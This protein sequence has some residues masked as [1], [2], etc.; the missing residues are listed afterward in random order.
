MR[1]LL[2]GALV[3]AFAC[4]DDDGDGDRTPASDMAVEG[5][6]Q[7]DRP[8]LPVIPDMN[9]SDPC[10]DG[11][12]DE[13]EACDTAIAD[14]EEGACPSTCADEDVCT[15]DGVSGT[16]CSATCTNAPITEPSTGDGCCPAGALPVNDRDCTGDCGNGTL[17]AGE[18]CDLGIPAGTPGACPAT[19]DDAIACTSD[20]MENAGTCMARCVYADIEAPAA[21]DGCCPDGANSTT[22]SDCSASCG[23][24]VVDPAETCDSGIAVG[25]PGA[26][27]RTCDDGDICTINRLRS[28]GTCNAACDF[29]PVP[30][31]SGDGCCAPGV[32]SRADSDCTTE[33]G[34]GALDL[35]ETCDDGNLVSGDGCDANCQS[36]TPVPTA[37]RITSLEVRDPHVFLP[38]CTID[39]TS[40]ANGIFMDAVERNAL[41]TAGVFR[42]IDP[43]APSTP[44]DVF[45]GAACTGA[46][47]PLDACAAS[48]PV[49]ATNANNQ[50]SGTCFAAP[51]STLSYPA[52]APNA[53][54]GSCFATTPS[55]VQLNLNGSLVTMQN[56]VVAGEYVPGGIRNG[57]LS[58]FVSYATARNTMVTFGAGSLILYD[59]LRG[60]GCPGDDDDPL[61]VGGADAG[62]WFHLDFEATEVSWTD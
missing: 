60:G 46:G 34:D 4:G 21:G 16:G 12:L 23:D 20:T 37:F 18:G 3:A 58:G 38:G 31:T 51:P 45:P 28:A 44:M 15:T 33:C 7:M 8:D 35:G 27:P 41:N 56:A 9:A 14:G 55:T 19:C 59:L 48:G 40:A 17:D 47:T 62:W 32:G 24:G 6:A 22:D 10:G 52:T 2:I 1:R 36:E 39:G 50:T 53:P 49:V 25:S 5:D 57:I 29:G 26:C 30:P 54:M 43:A 61:F 42:P 11:V 13:G